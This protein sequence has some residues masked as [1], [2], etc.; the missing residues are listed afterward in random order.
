[1][2][3]YS[4]HSFLHS[5]FVARNVPSFL[6]AN[7]HSRSHHVLQVIGFESSG[8]SEAAGADANYVLEHVD[9]DADD[10]KIVIEDMDAFL[11]GL[12]RLP[13]SHPTEDEEYENVQ[14]LFDVDAIQE[15]FGVGRREG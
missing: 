8:G 6:R 3:M 10:D 1:M 11:S 14:L 15:E 13:R 4:V 12:E 5:L 9:V 2:Y 7:L